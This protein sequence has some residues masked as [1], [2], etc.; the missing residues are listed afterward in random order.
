MWAVK[1]PKGALIPR[2]LS[3]TREDAYF[4]LFDL[5]PEDFRARYWKRPD[6][7]RKAYRRLGYRA[8]RA[9]LVEEV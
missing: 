7:S 4:S 2:T 3:S 9:R 6:E 8:V 1:N 5:M